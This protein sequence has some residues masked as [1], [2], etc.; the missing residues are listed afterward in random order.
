MLQARK[1]RART[2]AS[3]ALPTSVRSPQ[4]TSAWAFDAISGSRSRNKDVASSLT[5]RS[6]MAA[7]VSLS[8]VAAM[9]SALVLI[10]VGEAPLC[11]VGRVVDLRKHPAAANLDARRRQLELL[12]EPEAQ[13]V[14]E[15]ARHALPLGG[16]DP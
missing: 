15:P 2:S 13:F 8:E 3:R 11:D 10:R 1:S 5:C 14:D 9:I 4:R 7:K 6:P 16:I 12:L